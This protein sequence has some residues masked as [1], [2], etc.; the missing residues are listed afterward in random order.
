[1]RIAAIANENESSNLEQVVGK[2][3]ESNAFDKIIVYRKAKFGDA[4]CQRIEQVDVPN[5]RDTTPKF[6][7]FM[8]KHCRENFK[9]SFLHVIDDS[10]EILDNPAKFAGEIECL[11][12]V[13]DINNFFGTI[14]DGCNRVYKK[15]NPRLRIGIDRPEYQNLGFGSEILFCSHSNI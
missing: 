10:I 12:N 6:R 7:N 4:N 9:E 11:M 3:K 14:T 2:V 1:M 13:L 5:D 8:L 15:Y